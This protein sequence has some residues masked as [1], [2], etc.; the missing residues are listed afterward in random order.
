MKRCVLIILPIVQQRIFKLELIDVAAS[1][2]VWL[3]SLSWRNST[4]VKNELSTSSTSSLDHFSRKC[5]IYQK[6][7]SQMEAGNSTYKGENTQKSQ[8][9]QQTISSLGQGLM[10]GK[11]PKEND[12]IDETKDKTV[13]NKR[14]GQVREVIGKWEN[15]LIQLEVL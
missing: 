13:D 6:C 7:R 8:Y 11:W 14:L 15:G 2:C 12:L 1:I 10:E 9:K 3:V 4:D 5:P